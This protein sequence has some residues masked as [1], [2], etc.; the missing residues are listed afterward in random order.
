[1]P[2]QNTPGP[3]PLGRD[4]T[5]TERRAEPGRETGDVVTRRALAVRHVPFEDLGLAAGVLEAHGYEVTYLDS[6]LAPPLTPEALL[7]PDLVVVLGGPVGVGDTER[8]PFL[9]AERTAIGVRLRARRPT[10]GICLGAQLMAHALG[11]EVT[12]TGHHEIGYAPLTLTDAGRD[13]VLAPLAGV[14]VLHWHGDQFTIPPGSARLAETPGFPHQAFS[15]GS[16][17]LGLQFHLEA[18]HTRIEAWLVGHA[19]ELATAKVDPRDVRADAARHGPA[20]AD[21]ATRV[22]DAWVAQATASTEHPTLPTAT[23]LPPSPEE[24]A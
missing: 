21:A 15:S 4:E 10:L 9:A 5:R 18:D 1:M 17:A 6:P 7:G 8:Y 13:S 22:L 12:A 3:H 19:H 20:L 23:P 14:P 11:A 16:H 24:P 2:T